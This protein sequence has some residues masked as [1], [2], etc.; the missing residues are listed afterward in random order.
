MG[1]A[2]IKYGLIPVVMV[3][4]LLIA[5]KI[6]V[7]SFGH[8]KNVMTAPNVVSITAG[9]VMYMSVVPT[10]LLT[11]SIEGETTGIISAKIGGRIA[12]VL[13]EDGQQVSAGETLVRLESVE[14]SN[15]VGIARDGVNRL[16]A[17]YENSAADYNRYKLLYEQKAIAKQQLD[18]AET[19]MKMAETELSSAYASL[20]NAQEQR[21]YGAIKAPVNGVVANRTAVIGQVVSAGLPLMTIENIRQVYGVV[22]IEQKDMGALKTGLSA[23]I[24][25]DAYPGQV[26]AGTVHIINPVAASSN[27]MF[28][29][30][31]KLENV[32]DRL[33]PGMFV[34]AGIVLGPE[35]QS[36][37]VPK[38]A[39]FQ[40]QGL[41]YVYVIQNNKVVKQQF[42][43]GIVK[44][45]YIEVKTGLQAQMMIATSNINT[46]KDGDSILVT[47]A[48]SKK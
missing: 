32:H 26:F 8:T 29:A 21:E 6:G 7:L 25:V 2:K 31:I 37:F 41:Y 5:V 48:S 16:Q 44:G 23:E 15:A 13:V 33:K 42:E 18:S 47:R 4:G 27:R 10:L 43:V 38:N 30:K 34:K 3:V 17:N 1:R 12:E 28:R 40:K 22:N 19:K 9:E 35:I 14:L 36:L 20:S 24:I 46:L 45:D 39:V 11:G